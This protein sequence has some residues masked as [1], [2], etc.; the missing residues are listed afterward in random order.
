VPEFANVDD[1]IG[2]QAAEAQPRLRELRAVISA[3]L[4]GAR[5]VISYGIPTYKLGKGMVS[6]GAAKRHCA[7]YGSAMD[8][9][10]DELRSFGTSRGTVRFPLDQP[11]PAD[12]VRK[13]VVAKFA[14]PDA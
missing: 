2:A 14:T 4:P 12:L 10:P 3:A 13:L 6:F 7:L 11:I 5:E 8:A 9:F 1:Y